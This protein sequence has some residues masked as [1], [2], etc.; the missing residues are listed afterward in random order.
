MKNFDEVLDYVDNLMELTSIQESIL[1]GTYQGKK[2]F[3]I[4][5]EFNCSESH[6]KKEAA[7]LWQKLGQELDE[8]INKYNVRSKL[9][10]KYHVSQV[11]EFGYCLQVDEGN[12][13]ICDKSLQF[14][15][16]LSKKSF[17]KTKNKLPLIDLTEA[18]EINYNYDRDLEINH[19]KEWIENKTKLIKI[20]GLKGIG[21]TALILKLTSEIKTKF[22]Y[23]I[24]RSLDNKPKLINFKDNLKQ[25]F[26]TGE[27]TTE[28]IDYFKTFRCLIILEFFV[29][30]TLV[31]IDYPNTNAKKHPPKLIE[32]AF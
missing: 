7:K 18:P 27:L 5:Q 19:L 28:I 26:S 11:S 23:I 16:T 4:A 15:N 17:S 3:Q 1:R 24:Y 22:D 6:I 13:N 9:A 30:I 2:N 12:I 8:N 10:K 25:I 32:S 14:T 21:K 29:T 20:Y 31:I